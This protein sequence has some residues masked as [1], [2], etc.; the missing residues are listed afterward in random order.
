M[1]L[2]RANKLKLYRAIHAIDCGFYQ[3]YMGYA[4]LKK[5][6]LYLNNQLTHKAY[7]L[8]SQI[9]KDLLKAEKENSYGRT[10]QRSIN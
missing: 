6:G 9:N 4:A 1:R 5:A 7:V 10:E 2:R 3:H 8:W